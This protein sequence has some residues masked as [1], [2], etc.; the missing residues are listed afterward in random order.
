MI[1]VIIIYYKLNIFL[2][3]LLIWKHMEHRTS[4]RI[5]DTYYYA[6]ISARTFYAREMVIYILLVLNFPPEAYK[7][8]IYISKKSDGIAS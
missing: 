8:I 5:S 6:R 1:S 3:H 4:S 2:A 7:I